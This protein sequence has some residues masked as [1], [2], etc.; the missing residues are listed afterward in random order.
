MSSDAKC[1]VPDLPLA[2]EAALRLGGF[3]IVFA[4]VALWELARPRRPATTSKPLRWRH[5]LALAVINVLIVRA[6][7]P[8]AA[9]GAAAAAASRGWGVFNNVSIT[10]LIAVPASVVVLDLVVWLQHRLFHAIPL[11]WRL[12]R[13]HHADVDFDVTTGLRFHPL[14][15]LISMLLK[16]AVIVALGAPMLAV[17]VFELLL[18]ATSM[19]NHANAGLPSRIERWVRR[20]I[21]TPDMHRIHHS[22][23]ADEMNRN[24]GFNLSLWDRC[25]G[26]YREAPRGGNDGMTIGLSAWRGPTAIITL[27]RLL[28]MPFRRE[29]AATPGSA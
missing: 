23:A 27:P 9:V 7:F 15:M 29:P 11:L 14:E 24:F 19:F 13:V 16:M 10:A 12:H 2:P 25:F 22:I 21:V 28:D 18:N 3:L 4:A 17:L 6:L 5:N 1:E 8:L 26:T 20:L